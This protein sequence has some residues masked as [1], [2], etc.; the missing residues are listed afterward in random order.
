MQFLGVIKYTDQNGCFQFGGISSQSNL[1]ITVDK[2]GFK[3]F[4]ESK[5][6]NYYDID[7]FLKD[8]DSKM[9]SYGNWKRIKF[10]EISDYE[11]CNQ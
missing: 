8:I 7:I 11:K 6:F 2:I 3:K 4:K 5:E 10:E 1:R 9:S